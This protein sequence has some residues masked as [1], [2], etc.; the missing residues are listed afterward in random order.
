MVRPEPETRGDPK[1]TLEARVERIVSP[2]LAR[3]GV[4][5]VEVR[6]L[7]EQGSWTL[8]I[9]IDKPGGVSL[10][11]C[12][13]VSRSVEDVL[14][15]E[16]MIPHRYRLEVSSPGLDR[17]LKTESDFRRFFGRRVRIQTRE[18][19]EGRKNFKGRILACEEGVV[20]LQDAQGCLFRLPLALVAKSKLEIDLKP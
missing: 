3:Q 9:F 10:D 17:A 18:P 19:L 14:D 5:L 4:E 2:L 8:K 13:R 6:Y 1:G 15:V 7:R 12:V 20:T 11:D 16:D